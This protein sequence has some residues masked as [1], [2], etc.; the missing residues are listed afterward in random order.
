M[1][2]AKS[3]ALLGREGIAKTPKSIGPP[4]LTAKY[5]DPEAVITS[6]AALSVVT[7]EPGLGLFRERPIHH[8][9]AYGEEGAVDVGPKEPADMV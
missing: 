1:S 5:G 8:S 2:T 4:C 9:C 3:L 7:P 6:A